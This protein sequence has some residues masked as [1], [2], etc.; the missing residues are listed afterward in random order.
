MSIGWIIPEK[1]SKFSTVNLRVQEQ[2]EDQ[3]RDGG[4]V[5]GQILRREVLRVGGKHE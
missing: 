3:D 4:N 5:F 1:L 2:E